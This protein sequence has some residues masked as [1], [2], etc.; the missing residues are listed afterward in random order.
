[1]KTTFLS[2]LSILTVSLSAFAADLSLAW[3][4]SPGA[5]NYVLYAS[6]S[7]LT[8]TTLTNATLKINVGT[9][10]TA[11]VQNLATGQWY[12]GATAFSGG[13]QSDLSNILVVGSPAPPA[14]MRTMIVQYSFNL[15]TN[16]WNDLGFFRLKLP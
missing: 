10:L 13:L 9:N 1:M 2:I 5:T 4:P 6:Q 11:T 12:F 7:P 3:D 14:N 15:A 8:P 16:G